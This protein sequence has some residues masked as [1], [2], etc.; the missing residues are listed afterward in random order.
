MA[1]RFAVVSEKE[2]IISV[3]KEAVPNDTK[4]ATKFVYLWHS[5]YPSLNT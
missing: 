5:E 1:S 2:I 3:N 4:M